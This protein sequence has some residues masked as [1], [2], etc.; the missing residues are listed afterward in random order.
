[1]DDVDGEAIAEEWDVEGCCWDSS[2]SLRSLS[3]ALL[4]SA[5]LLLCFVPRLPSAVDM[6]TGRWRLARE[7]GNVDDQAVQGGAAQPRST[8]GRT[9]R[10]RHTTV[11]RRPQ[12]LG[13]HGG[14]YKVADGCTTGDGLVR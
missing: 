12:R 9:S 4:L 5:G 7:W 11:R 13:V 1:M 10:T 6:S 3:A 14:V 2:R 8:A